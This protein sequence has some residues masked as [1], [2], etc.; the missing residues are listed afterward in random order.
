M[1]QALTDQVPVPLV[2]GVHGDRRVTEHGLDPGGGHHQMRLR[3][4]HRPVPEGDQ[5]T[6]DVGVLDLEVGDRGLQHRRPVHQ[7]LG[8]I[9]QPRVVEALEDG[10]HRPGQA[11]VH[12][13]AV[14]TPVDAVTKTPHL[15]ADGAAG[16]VLPVPH[17]VDEQFPAE[18]LLRLTVHRELLLHHALGRDARVVHAGQPQHLVALHALA[19][20]EGVHQRVVERVPHV[21][22]AGHVRWRQHDRIRRFVAR[23]VGREVARIDPALIQLG[24]YCGRIPRLREGLHPRALCGFRADGHLDSLGS[25]TRAVAKAPGSSG[26]RGFRDCSRGLLLAAEQAAQDV[27]E[28]AALA[29]AEHAAED[30]AQGVVVRGCAA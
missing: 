7:P 3:V 8:L 27:A 21:Q 15:R 16:L 25:P 2:V 17:L 6:L 14:P 22:A 10:A 30:A 24:L 4:I 28:A 5:L 12:G 20:G 9:D 29:A 26:F 13:E 23:R 19:S 1:R 11:L 18:V